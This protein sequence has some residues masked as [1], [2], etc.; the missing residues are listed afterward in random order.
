MPSNRP[1]RAPGL[2]ERPVEGL[3][4]A[5]VAPEHLAVLGEEGRRTE[6]AAREH[7]LAHPAQA[8]L[9]AVGQRLRED[10]LRIEAEI[11][12]DRA[13]DLRVGDVPAFAELG[14]I[15]GLG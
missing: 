9:V 12:Q 8:H 7:L 2:G 14:R 1:V 3:F 5:V 13:Q 4:E 6:D 11:R 10:R 15:D